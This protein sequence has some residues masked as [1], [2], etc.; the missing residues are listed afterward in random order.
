MRGQRRVQE[1]R[2]TYCIPKAEASFHFL[3]WALDAR[4]RLINKLEGRLLGLL[5]VIRARIL[6]GDGITIV[7]RRRVEIRLGKDSESSVYVALERK[8]WIYVNNTAI[9]FGSCETY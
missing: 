2:A 8:T 9:N 1:R 4:E 6:L 3:R 5:H 7:D